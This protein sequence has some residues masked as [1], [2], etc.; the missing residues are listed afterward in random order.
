MHGLSTLKKLNE[1]FTPEEIAEGARRSAAAKPNTVIEGPGN[2]RK[3][4]DGPGKGTEYAKPGEDP[5]T[6]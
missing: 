5:G 2:T 3:Y 6:I 1:R 4:I